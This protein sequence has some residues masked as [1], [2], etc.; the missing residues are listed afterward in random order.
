[1]ILDEARIAHSGAGKNADEAAAPA[2]VDLTPQTRLLLF[3]F[4]STSSGIPQEWRATS[5]HAGVNLL[6]DLSEATAVRIA[7]QMRQ[8]QQPGDSL[9]ASI[10]WGRNWGSKFPREQI[11]S[12]NVLT[13]KV[14]P[15]VHAHPR[16]H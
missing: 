6:E 2:I 14:F 3:S 12:A 16:I 15:P 5:L 10:H 4:G 8:H 7:N 11:P 9:I 13:I 1:H